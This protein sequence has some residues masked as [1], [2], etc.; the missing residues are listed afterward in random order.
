MLY[1][2]AA[3]QMRTGKLP[4][5]QNTLDNTLTGLL[6]IRCPQYSV[7]IPHRIPILDQPQRSPRLLIPEQCLHLGFHGQHFTARYR[8]ELV[9]LGAQRATAE[10]QAMD[11]A[12]EVGDQVGACAVVGTREK[13]EG[14]AGGHF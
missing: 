2:A 4:Y 8:Q 7:Q 14:G 1:M 11:D 9:L 6:R 10:E 3:G 13:D 12:R 5:V